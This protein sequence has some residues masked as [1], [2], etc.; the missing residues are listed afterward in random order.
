MG[1]HHGVS[2]SDQVTQGL[3]RLEFGE[4]N[5]DM[6]LSGH[7]KAGVSNLEAPLRLGQ[8]EV[9]KTADELVAPVAD[10]QVV[11]TDHA[12][13][14]VDNLAQQLVPGRVALRIVQRLETV[15]VHE[16][17]HEGAARSVCLRH[18]ALEFQQSGVASV[19][20]GE[21]VKKQCGTFNG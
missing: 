15:D 11:L 19:D 1:V 4:A 12:A 2:A 18:F 17:E 3:V 21:S 7:S 14:G 6:R 13:D 8:I 20:A 16:G 5:A 9:K 10:D